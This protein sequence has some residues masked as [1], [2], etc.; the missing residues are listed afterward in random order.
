MTDND[1]SKPVVKEQKLIEFT[2]DGD[3]FYA[4]PSVGAGIMDD[5][6]DVNDFEGLTNLTPEDA[7][8][9]NVVALMKANH[10]YNV[11]LMSFLDQVL[12]EE[13]AQ[14]YASR[15]RMAGE[16]SIDREQSQRVVRFLVEQYSKP[17]PTEPP[18]SSSN[19][20]GGTR[21]SSTAGR[22]AKG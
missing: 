9:E 14:L 17:H 21:R 10:N 7:T 4:Y 20:R 11:R 15:L 18:A 19:G 6:L 16:R 1:F 13:S 12:T 2:L 3:T 5:I 8:T 22:Q